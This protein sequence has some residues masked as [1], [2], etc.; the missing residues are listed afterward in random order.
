MKTSPCRWK[1]HSGWGS[2]G[3]RGSHTRSTSSGCT[4]PSP[5][6][7]GPGTPCEDVHKLS[8]NTISLIYK[9]LVGNK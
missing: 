7:I 5:W 6:C 3:P 9:I 4:G 8:E 1:E 2:P